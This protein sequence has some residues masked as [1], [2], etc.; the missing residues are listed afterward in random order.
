MGQD[1]EDKSQLKTVV[2]NPQSN[3]ATNNTMPAADASVVPIQ[4]DVKRDEVGDYNVYKA[5]FY[6]ICILFFILGSILL[7]I[8]IYRLLKEGGYLNF[9]KTD[10]KKTVF[11][12]KNKYKVDDKKENIDSLL[13]D[14]EKEIF[15]FE[16]FMFDIGD[17]VLEEYIDRLKE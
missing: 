5:A 17:T 4:Q 1:Q 2:E 7:T 12:Y 16:N 3:T 13:F 6:I 14:L 8:E 15:R 11:L 9:S 10:T